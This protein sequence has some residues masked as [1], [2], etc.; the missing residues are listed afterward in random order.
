MSNII[1][2]NAATSA[3]RRVFLLIY[4][5]TDGTTPWAG[6]VTGIKAKL[7]FR[8]GSEAD[9]TDDI[10]RLAGAV[11]YV[12]LTQTEANTNTGAV[13]A[14]VP[15]ASGRLEGLGIA[16]IVNYDPHAAGD[17]SV[18]QPELTAAPA[19]NNA[20]PIDML[21]WVYHYLRNARV[22]TSTADTVKRDDG[23]TTLAT[24]TLSDSS[25]TLTWGE[26]T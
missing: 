16:E 1:Q 15:A 24:A 25:G 19:V 7:S 26:Y 8:G 4:S 11:H 20:A 2:K 21:R 10:A 17:F 14:R 23:S 9:S 3:L 5:D 12:E 13:T 18:Q 22:T 6:S